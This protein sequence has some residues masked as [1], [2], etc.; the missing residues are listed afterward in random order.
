MKFENVGVVIATRELSLDEDKKVEVLIG[1]PEPFPDGIDWY[2]P[3][4]II[5]IGSGRVGWAGGVDPVQALVL[6]LQNVGAVLVCSPEFELGRLS[7]E[8][9]GKRR[10]RFSACQCVERY[11]AG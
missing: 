9:L 6:A 8:S 10:S 11:G 7:W 5:G 2:C 1:K 4:K 3:Y